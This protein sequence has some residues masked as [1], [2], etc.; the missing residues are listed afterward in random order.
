MSNFISLH[1]Q[2]SYS[3]L[4]SLCSV[5]DLF[6][7]A[8]E[9]NQSAIAIT[10]HGTLA[11]TW[12]AFKLY[13]STGIK[14]I[15]GCECYFTND[16]SNIESKMRHVIFIAKNAIGYRNLLTINKKGFDQGKVAGNACGPGLYGLRLWV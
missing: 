14:L 8:K 9:F 7:K 6:N 1:N 3:L 11:A 2:T 13:K 5:K 4:D 10:D 12:E 15:I 16:A